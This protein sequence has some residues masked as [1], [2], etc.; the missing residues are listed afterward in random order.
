MRPFLDHSQEALCFTPVC[1][2]VCPLHLNKVCIINSSHSFWA[3]N[4]NLG[5]YVAGILKMCT[6]LFENEEVMFDKITAFSNLETFEKWPITEYH[7]CIPV[8]NSFQNFW[9]INLKPDTDNTDL[10][11]VDVHLP[12]WKEKK[13]NI[14]D[15]ITVF[16]FLR[17]YKN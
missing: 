14:F 17:N 10:H 4:L 12:F 11:F 15:K 3:I 6:C 9:A 13:N 16:H 1:L 5:T 8:I 7:V 2:F